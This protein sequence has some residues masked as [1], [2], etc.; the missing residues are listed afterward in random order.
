MEHGGAFVFSNEIELIKHM[1]EC[2]PTVDYSSNSPPLLKTTSSTR[3]DRD[4]GESKKKA[5]GKARNKKGG[6][7]DLFSG[8]GSG[9]EPMNIDQQRACVGCFELVKS[10]VATCPH[11]G[12]EDDTI[13]LPEK[14]STGESKMALEE[15]EHSKSTAEAKK[16]ITH[17][18]VNR[19]KDGIENDQQECKTD[20][21][22]K[23][24]KNIIEK[25]KRKAEAEREAE[26]VERA[27][28]E[29][30][31]VAADKMKKETVK[32]GQRMLQQKRRAANDL[33]YSQVHS[34]TNARTKQ[35]GGETKSGNKAKKMTQ[36]ITQEEKAV[37]RLQK[38]ERKEI[39]D[40]C[41]TIQSLLGDMKDD[42]NRQEQTVSRESIQAEDGLLY[43]QKG[44]CL[45]NGVWCVKDMQQAIVLFDKA[46]KRGHT[47]G[48][49][50][51]NEC[52]NKLVAVADERHQM[53]I[54]EKQEFTRTLELENFSN[55][56]LQEGVKS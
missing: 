45:A 36:E 41:A 35:F 13:R 5:Q 43:F 6:D 51:A 46:A 42:E 1:Q 40:Q 8:R 20:K 39:N 21:A 26:R 15:E 29:Q 25:N 56:Q 37:R 22:L 3:R 47:L 30:A 38:Q 11:C 18:R 44:M 23:A 32:K 19:K 55:V 31:A 53:L 27:V 16:R 28:Q 9:V 50:K 4:R 34:A 12:F 7:D 14:K 49:S 52:T 48:R 54:Q 24:S 17:N 2:H 33:K 10:T